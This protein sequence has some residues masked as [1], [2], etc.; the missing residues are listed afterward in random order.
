MNLFNCPLDEAL[1]EIVRQSCNFKIGQG[2]KLVFGIIGSTAP[3][4][5]TTILTKTAWDALVTAT[6][7]TKIVVT[8][9]I[10]NLVIPG[11]DAVE[12][13]GE[14]N[15]NR[16]PELI[17]G[18][19]AAAT[20]NPRGIEPAIR[21]AMQKLT[22]Y[23]AIQ[24]GVTDLGFFIINSDGDIVCDATNVWIPVYN[25][26]LGDSDV[27]A[28]KGKS[29]SSIGKFMLAFGWSNNLK[30]YTPSFNILATYP[31]AA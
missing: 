28:E 25:F 11:T 14:T 29:N 16:M 3:F 23:S 21:A 10:N 30:K 31:I 17:D 5:P 18:G 7:E 20:F 1:T 26:F 24:P 27:V 19:N 6:D 4:T 8:N 9:Y 12:E 2:A 22:P 15:L 13:G